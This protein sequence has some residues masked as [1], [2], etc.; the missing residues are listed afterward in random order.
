MT[1]I[2]GQFVRLFVAFLSVS[3]SLTHKA[4]LLIL[5]PVNIAKGLPGQR[6]LAAC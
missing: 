3:I 1:P 6:P 5:P 2:Q 4:G